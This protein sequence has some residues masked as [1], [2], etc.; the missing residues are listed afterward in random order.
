MTVY[1][2]YQ[3]EDEDKEIILTEENNDNGYNVI[4]Y[5]AAHYEEYYNQ[6]HGQ[7]DSEMW[8][9][10][11]SENADIIDNNVVKA[12]H[13]FGAGASIPTY[14]SVKN[15]SA[16]PNEA[17]IDIAW[18]DF[19]IDISNGFLL[20]LTL[21]RASQIFSIEISNDEESQIKSTELSFSN[22]E[23]LAFSRTGP[24]E[25]SKLVRIPNYLVNAEIQ[26]IWTNGNTSIANKKNN[27][28]VGQN[29]EDNLGFKIATNNIMVTNV[30]QNFNV[31][32]VTVKYQEAQ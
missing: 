31:I 21:N 29:W 27:Y 11:S 20:T 4:N 7:F 28:L 8:S 3:W 13:K 18:N 12:Y 2:Q 30:E 19:D 22:C 9:V 17:R 1:V 6:N 24:L 15:L 26:T 5:T 10:L 23:L 25:C 32:Y 16:T 14:A